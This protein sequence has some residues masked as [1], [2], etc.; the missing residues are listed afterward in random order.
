MDEMIGKKFGRLTI[1]ELDHRDKWKNKHYKC[2]CECGTIK[3]IN[4]GSLRTGR[5]TSCGC[6]NL[7]ILKQPHPDRR[8]YNEF[9]I[10]PNFVRVKDPN[11]DQYFLCDLEDWEIFKDKLLKI[12]TK[13]YVVFVSGKYFSRVIMKAPETLVVDHIN[14]DPLDNRKINLRVC[15]QIE[16]MRNLKTPKDNKSGY[17]GVWRDT[18]CQKWCAEIRCNKVKYWL[19]RFENIED[20]IRARE[21]AEIKYF[22]EFRRKIS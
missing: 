15:K 9:R 12:S 1:L 13:G 19:G 8:K 10:H 20:A 4:V 22:G 11:H 17:K 3:A 2:I 18:V 14:G 16:N 7:E 21:E 5:T 6:Y